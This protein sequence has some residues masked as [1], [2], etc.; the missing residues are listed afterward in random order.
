MKVS[1]SVLALFFPLLSIG[2]SHPLSPMDKVTHASNLVNLK[3]LPL[4]WNT[5]PP[6]P[7]P[8]QSTFILPWSLPLSLSSVTHISAS[9]PFSHTSITNGGETIPPARQKTGTNTMQYCPIRLWKLRHPMA[10][11]TRRGWTVEER[12]GFLVESSSDRG[13]ELFF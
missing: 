4:P 5:T 9:Q 13:G 7:K 6:P 8:S 11:Q 2:T 3:N 10:N 12:G 1:P